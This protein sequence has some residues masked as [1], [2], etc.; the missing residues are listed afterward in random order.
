MQGR[1]HLLPWQT[2]D[3]KPKTVLNALMYKSSRQASG[4]WT[5]TNRA[6]EQPSQGGAEQEHLPCHGHLADSDTCTIYRVTPLPQGARGAQPS[7]GYFWKRLW[8][9]EATALKGL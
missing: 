4:S 7:L 8:G 3:R 6:L 5:R 2:Q 9:A 1:P